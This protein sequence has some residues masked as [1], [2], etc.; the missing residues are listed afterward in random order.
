[1]YL[2]T[3]AEMGEIDRL[4]GREYFI[5]SIVLMENAGLRVVESIRRYFGG[6]VRA[7]RVVIFA[8]KGNNGGDGLVV[9]RHLHNEGAEVKVFLLARPEELRG[10][11]RT[12]LEIYQKMGGKIFPL[13]EQIQLQRADISLLYADLVVDAIF[14]TG[15]KGAALGIAG[16]VI[17][18]IN[19]AG[20]PVVAVDLPSGLEADTG[21]FHGPCV[22]ATWTVTFALPKLGLAL[23]PGAGVAGRVEVADIGI[24][25]QLIESRGLK[26]C[27]LTPEWCRPYLGLREATAHKGTFGHVLVVGGSRGMTGAAALAAMGAI[28]AGAGLVTAAVPQSVQSILASQSREIM[29]RGLPETAAGS[30]SREALPVILELLEKCQVMAIGPGLSR[31]PA[32]AAL[33]RQLLPQVRCPVV[34]DADALNALAEEP[35]WLNDPYKKAEVILTPHPGEMARLRGTT[36]AR[37][38]ENRLG[39]ASEAAREWQAVVVLK[40]ARTVIACPTGEVYV[41]PTGNPG[42]ATGGSGDVLTGIVAGLVAQGLAPAAAAALGAYVHGAAGDRAMA[43]KGQRGLVA[44]DLLDF[45]PRV[46]RKLERGK[47]ASEGSMKKSQKIPATAPRHGECCG[48]SAENRGGS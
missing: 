41:N 16:E 26:V 21:R 48:S 15:F 22:R 44:G 23:E 43:V 7:K 11:P 12:N 10:D 33:V 45:L 8:G 38:Q 35:E 5:P 24:P 27:L 34:I 9:A 30:L 37:V 40:G 6:T 25:R 36:T 31:D 19:K 46:W 2:V 17:E 42:M 32:T 29:T 47:V 1:M 4:A 18:L 3:S 14:G 13:V 20:K 28:R 39:T